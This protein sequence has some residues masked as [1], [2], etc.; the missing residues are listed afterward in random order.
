L[1]QI[2]SI[3]AREIRGRGATNLSELLSNELSFR[4]TQ[5]A[6]LGSSLSLNGLTGEHVKILIDGVPI[7]GRQAQNLDLTQINLSKVDHIEVVEG[8]MSVIYGSNALGGVI[9]IIT[10]RP[11]YGDKG[12]YKVRTYYE[13]VGVYNA[14]IEALF[15][16][17]K[18]TFDVSGGRHF[19]GGFSAPGDSLRY[20]TWKPKLQWNGNVDYSMRTDKVKLNVSSSIF[21]EEL[22]N[23]GDRIEY[24]VKAPDEYHYTTRSL[25]KI[26]VSV[27]LGADITTT[28]LASYSYY[29][30][31][32]QT[33]VKDLV[34]LSEEL[35]SDP[36]AHDTTTF[37]NLMGRWLLGGKLVNKLDFQTGLE[38]NQEDGSGKRINGDQSIHEAS[39]FGTLKYNVF[40]SFDLQAGLRYIN[41]SR[42]DAP[43]IYNFNS[44]WDIS[45][46][47]KLRLSYGKGFRAPSLK[48]LYFEFVDVNHN[49]LGNKDLKAEESVYAGL[50]T[51]VIFSKQLILSVNI[52]QNIIDNKIDLLYDSTDPSKAQYYNL[53]GKRTTLRGLKLLA[54]IE[55]NDK[56]KIQAGSQIT[57]QSKIK[58]SGYNWSTDASLNASYNLNKL[59][60]KLSLYY[61]YNGKYVFYT[62]NYDETGSLASVNENF[63][64]RYHSLDFIVT[65]WLWKDKLEIST[66]IKNAFDNTNI[67]GKGSTGVHSGGGQNDNPVAWGRTFFLQ[68]Q[69]S[70]NYDRKISK[71]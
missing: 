10:Q 39:G 70:L 36:K 8:P 14:D 58:A 61:K 32:K 26:D 17:N 66:G 20:K 12:I 1:Y 56:L 22:R 42:F 13:T 54:N 69:L 45:S 57:G 53:S 65:K 31:V 11:V 27:P 38:Y 30:K 41:N 52:F 43:L 46:K 44:L 25:N 59:K 34:N 16:R 51:D 71:D 2:K 5:D 29:K 50:N 3:S 62:A 49:V 33:K 21:S 9:N 40:K 4:I 28:F 55:F 6:A 35:S 18:H 63:L 23:K 64:N 19:F 60:S 48:E 15:T 47:V 68:L 24:T 7:V 37:D 67:T